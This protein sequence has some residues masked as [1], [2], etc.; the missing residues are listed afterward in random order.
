[1]RLLLLKPLF[2]KTQINLLENKVEMLSQKN[3]LFIYLFD[4]LLLPTKTNKKLFLGAKK[5][6]FLSTKLDK[7]FSL[8]LRKIK[9]RKIIPT[10]K[11]IY[12]F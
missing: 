10:Q 2:L 1:M 7:S 8:F 3:N 6:V 11:I 9:N 5:C 12:S 4:L